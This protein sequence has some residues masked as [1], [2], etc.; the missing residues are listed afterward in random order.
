LQQQAAIRS[1][2]QPGLLKGRYQPIP[3][4]PMPINILLKI[5]PMKKGI[6]M[7]FKTQACSF[8]ITAQQ[9]PYM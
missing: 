3:V 7:H 9:A 5:M 2:K 1:S 6:R 8:V 4:K